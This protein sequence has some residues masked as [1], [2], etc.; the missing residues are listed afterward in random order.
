LSAHLGPVGYASARGAVDRDGY[1]DRA[2]ADT[3]QRTIDLE[4][5]ALLRRAQDTAMELLEGHANHLE[6]LIALLLEEETL[7]GARVYELVGV[8]APE[9]TASVRSSPVKV[10]DVVPVPTAEVDDGARSGPASV[11]PV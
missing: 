8:A 10:G 2:F 1:G 7:D 9:A 6:Q 11:A 3:T 5:R 4:V